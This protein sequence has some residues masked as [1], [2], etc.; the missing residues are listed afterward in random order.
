MA[1]S[2]SWA[3]LEQG[4]L[5]ILDWAVRTG[6]SRS[7]TSVRM[8]EYASLPDVWPYKESQLFVPFSFLGETIGFASIWKTYSY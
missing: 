3:G 5:I 2:D 7:G 6:G 8:K 4:Y 1:F